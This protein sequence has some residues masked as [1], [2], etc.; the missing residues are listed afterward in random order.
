[1][2]ELQ[3]IATKVKRTKD[4]QLLYEFRAP[5]IT[6]TNFIETGYHCAI[7]QFR[8]KQGSETFKKGYKADIYYIYSNKHTET[9]NTGVF[10]YTK[11]SG[12]KTYLSLGGFSSPAERSNPCP[13][14]IK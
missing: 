14:K 7:G 3:N 1:V 8:F 6:G 12:P 13:S 4:S 9:G 2:V 11:S 5:D 10:S